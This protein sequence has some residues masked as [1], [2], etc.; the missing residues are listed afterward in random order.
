[1][2]RCRGS[3]GV[4]FHR[5]L[6][7]LCIDLPVI[8]IAGHGDVRMSVRAMRGGAIDFLTKPFRHD[9]LLDRSRPAPGPPVGPVGSGHR[10]RPAFALRD[11]AAREQ[12]ILGLVVEGTLNKIDAARLGLSE[13]TVKVQ[14]AR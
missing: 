3:A 5:E 12:Q 7:K 1:M 8:F 6:D 4:D 14:R 9:E 11:A 10:R 13:I 2:S